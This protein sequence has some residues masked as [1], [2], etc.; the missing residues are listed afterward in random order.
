MNLKIYLDDFRDDLMDHVRE[1]LRHNLAYEI[2][3]VTMTGVD[4]ETATA[5]II[6]DYLNRNNRGW[7]ISL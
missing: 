7:E 2:E 6:D 3:A 1:T 5:E 4:P